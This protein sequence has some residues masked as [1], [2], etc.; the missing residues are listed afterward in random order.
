MLGES[1]RGELELEGGMNHEIHEIRERRGGVKR[2]N[3]GDG[4]SEKSNLDKRSDLKSQLEGRE[5]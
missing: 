4:R 3:E 2:E 1:W 5:E